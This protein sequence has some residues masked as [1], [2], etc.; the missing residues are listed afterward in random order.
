MVLQPQRPV[1]GHMSIQIFQTLQT[2]IWSAHHLVW[3][4][5]FQLLL[6]VL[7]SAINC[8]YSYMW[9]LI[10]SK[11]LA[12]LVVKVI[13]QQSPAVVMALCHW[14]A[15]YSTP[16]A[17]H[18]KTVCSGSLFYLPTSFILNVATIMY[19]GRLEQL[20][21]ITIRNPQQ[22]SLDTSLYSHLFAH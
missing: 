1:P 20:H 21:C 4:F 5:V 7:N 22:L 15:L 11:Y 2:H 10:T 13:H 12:S 9:P 8:M 19:S 17:Y 18:C 16:H 6:S 14:I 3:F